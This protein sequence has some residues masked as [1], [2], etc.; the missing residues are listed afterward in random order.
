MKC[1]QNSSEKT[2]ARV[3]FLIKLQ[4]SAWNSKQGI[5]LFL[6]ILKVTSAAKR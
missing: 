3:S 2:F 5:D 4:A 6:E 1:L